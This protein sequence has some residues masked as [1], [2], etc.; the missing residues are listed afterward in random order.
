MGRKRINDEATMA[1]FPGGTLERIENV[2]GDHEKTADFI[3]AAIAR[4]L[5]KR[6][7]R[8]TRDEPARRSA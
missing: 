4:E 5:A 3:R 6:E 2:L 1:R 8:Q 7:R